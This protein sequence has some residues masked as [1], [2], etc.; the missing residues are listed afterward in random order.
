MTNPNDPNQQMQLLAQNAVTAA[1]EKFGFSLTFTES[2]LPQFEALLEKAHIT[3]QQSMNNGTQSPTMLQKTVSVWGSYFGE[4]I[5]RNLGGAWILD[6][7]RPFLQI[8]RLCFD[9]LGQVQS[10]ITYGEHYNL[11]E[12]YQGVRT[13]LQNAPAWQEKQ[14]VKLPAVKPPMEHIVIDL[15]PEDDRRQRQPAPLPNNHPT[16]PPAPRPAPRP[17]QNQRVDSDEYDFSFGAVLGRGLRNLIA[18]PVAGVY[19]GATWFIAVLILYFIGSM[20]QSGGGLG[21]VIVSIIVLIVLIMMFAFL[22]PLLVLIGMIL[23]IIGGF[24]G[25]VAGLAM[26]VISFL[27]YIMLSGSS[28]LRVIRNIL[29]IT[30]N[31]GISIFAI[32]YSLQHTLGFLSDPGSGWLV[33]VNYLMAAAFGLVIGLAF[34]QDKDEVINEPEVEETGKKN[35]FG[36]WNIYRGLA[37]GI[38]GA[39]DVGEDVRRQQRERELNDYIRSHR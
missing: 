5:R 12:Y 35:S 19:A 9:P 6:Q 1:R 33:V 14:P 37:R 18:G 38:L 11:P 8:G 15:P 29:I 30:A 16:P 28:G 7:G 27:L 24:V 34:L 22:G 20:F 25:G 36:P 32:G 23:G 26:G 2:N 21:G 3:Y 31:M 17:M 10:R 4:A 39:S 13:A